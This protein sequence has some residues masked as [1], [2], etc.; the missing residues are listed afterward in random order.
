MGS[1]VQNL[2][3][4]LSDTKKYFIPKK[5]YSAKK[6]LYFTLFHHSINV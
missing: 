6:H 2:S 3:N 4:S 1:E 5:K